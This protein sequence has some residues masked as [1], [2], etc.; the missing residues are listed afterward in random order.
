M[1]HQDRKSKTRIVVNH[2]SLTQAVNELL[3]VKGRTL[4]FAR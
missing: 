3:T 4:H 1:S 2:E